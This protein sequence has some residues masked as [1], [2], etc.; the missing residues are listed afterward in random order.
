MSQ[1]NFARYQSQNNKITYVIKNLIIN[2]IC[3]LSHYTKAGFAVYEAKVVRGEKI[4]T[5]L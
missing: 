5:S 1:S 4:L 3:Y 2:N